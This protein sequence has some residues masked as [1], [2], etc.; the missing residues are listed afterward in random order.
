MSLLRIIFI[1]IAVL[2]R[3]DTIVK[4]KRVDRGMAVAKILAEH[5]SIHVDPAD[6]WVI[7]IGFSDFDIVMEGVDI[8]CGTTIIDKED[9]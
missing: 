6:A 9:L 5:R 8:L 1:I 4:E 7:T 2:I 3:Y